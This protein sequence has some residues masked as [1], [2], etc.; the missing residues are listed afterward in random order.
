MNTISSINLENSIR[1]INNIQKYSSLTQKE[2]N[3]GFNI[4]MKAKVHLMFEIESPRSE[5]KLFQI[6]EKVSKSCKIYNQEDL[7]AI[8]NYIIDNKDEDFIND[9]SELLN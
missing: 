8:V 1:K 6:F 3:Q 7:D 9:I 2:L 4:I 5:N